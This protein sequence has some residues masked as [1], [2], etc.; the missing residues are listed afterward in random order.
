MWFEVVDKLTAY[1]QKQEMGNWL[2]SY[3]WRWYATLTFTNNVGL[4]TAKALFREFIDELDSSVIYFVAFEW[5]KYRGSCHIHALIG[6]LDSQPHW[7]YGK[8]QFKQYDKNGGARF[9]VTKFIT[10]RYTDWDFKLPRNEKE[11]LA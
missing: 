9:Y 11:G 6:G 8:S 5:H 10:N 3:D 1:R 2:S 7:Y 4:E